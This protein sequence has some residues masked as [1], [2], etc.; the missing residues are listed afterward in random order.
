M[1]DILLDVTNY[2]NVYVQVYFAASNLKTFSIENNKL[3][4]QLPPE[5]IKTLK[6]Y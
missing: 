2:Q 3:Q 4:E 6:S 5:T 1:C